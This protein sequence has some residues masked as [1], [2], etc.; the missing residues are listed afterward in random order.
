MTTDR[1]PE[2]RLA[3]LPVW[4]RMHLSTLY[5]ERDEALALAADVA[6]RS[7]APTGA[8][9]TIADAL[10]RYPI[11]LAP[12]RPVRFVLGDGPEEWVEAHTDTIGGRRVVDVRSG[13]RG[14]AVLPAASNHARLTFARD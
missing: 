8:S 9:D 12:G 11:N 14:L 5:R 6:A 10:G 7:F 3:K 1:L 4:A 13:W 2:E